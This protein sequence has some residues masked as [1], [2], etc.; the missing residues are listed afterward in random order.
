MDIEG[1]KIL[2]LG[3]YGLVGMAVCRELI[4]CRAGEIQIHSLRSEEA[5]SAREE[6]APEAGSTTLTTSA[7]EIF[8]LDY[9]TDRRG[10]IAAQ[11]EQLGGAAHR[12]AIP[13]SGCVPVRER[14]EALGVRPPRCAAAIS[15]LSR[16]DEL[17]GGPA[18]TLA[19]SSFAASK[20][21]GA[22]L[23]ISRSRSRSVAV[24]GL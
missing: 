12:L 3:G 13:P 17:G 4:A 1:R 16:A 21:P 24:T 15:S 20:A 14:L 23:R 19:M 11:L 6:L 7:G 9:E 5:E 22:R 2:V 18:A 8:G 10:R